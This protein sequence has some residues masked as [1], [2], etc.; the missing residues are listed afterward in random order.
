[1]LRDPPGG[2]STATWEKGSTSSV[3]LTLDTSNAEG[4]EVAGAF[5]PGIHQEFGVDIGFA[6]GA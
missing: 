4:L 3:A 2:L 6:W 5:G 1:V